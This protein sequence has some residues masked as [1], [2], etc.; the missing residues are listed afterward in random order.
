VDK[1]ITERLEDNG[2]GNAGSLNMFS[3]SG[4]IVRAVPG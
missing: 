4:H 2:S 1:N 3:G